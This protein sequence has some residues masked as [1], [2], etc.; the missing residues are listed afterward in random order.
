MLTTGRADRK[1]GRENR[2]D[3]RDK[4]AWSKAMRN[5]IMII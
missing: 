4:T 1:L 5:V 2:A 3:K